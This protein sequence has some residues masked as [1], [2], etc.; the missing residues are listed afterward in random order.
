M[1]ALMEEIDFY[2]KHPPRCQIEFAIRFEKEMM[3]PPFKQYLNLLKDSIIYFNHKNSSIDIFSKNCEFIR[4]T[5]I[6]YHLSNGWTSELLFDKT[7]GK[8]Y[9]IIKNI[10][11]EINLS[12]GEI[13]SKTKIDISR[14]VLINNGYAYVLKKK[15]YVRDSE[16]FID[17]I[18]LQSLSKTKSAPSASKNLN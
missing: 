16:T 1:Q 12:S 14:K 13:I 3:L 4:S 7:Q 17:K 9:T 15:L 18:K 11:Y 2:I 5:S 8:I 10:L 6:Y